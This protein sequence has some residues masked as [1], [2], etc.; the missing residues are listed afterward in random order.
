MGIEMTKHSSPSDAEQAASD[1]ITDLMH[2]ACLHGAD[3]PD[4]LSRA[5]EHYLGEIGGDAPKETIDRFRAFV[6]DAI[7]EATVGA[8]LAT[9]AVQERLP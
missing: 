2:F 7:Y 8:S 6:E 1:F 3:V 5:F 9:P 4:V